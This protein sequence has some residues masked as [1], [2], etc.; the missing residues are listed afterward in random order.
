MN[1]SYGINF[2]LCLMFNDT[3]SA[4]IWNKLPC[5]KSSI[6]DTPVC[7][8]SAAATLL[9]PI[10]NIDVLNT[11]L[12]TTDPP[13]IDAVAPP[14][15]IPEIDASNTPEIPK[16]L[17]IWITSS[18]KADFE[19]IPAILPVPNNNIAALCIFI[20]PLAIYVF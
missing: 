20:S 19:I 14:I 11:E 18:L 4:L 6:T 8:I 17:I 16:W 13:V 1:I 10:F 7:T 3:L 5:G 12:V 2:A 15:S 9:T